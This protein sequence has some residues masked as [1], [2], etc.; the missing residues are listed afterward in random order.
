MWRAFDY[1][2][3]SG[4]RFR[5]EREGVGTISLLPAPK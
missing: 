4:Y 3:I 1:L 2:R 5:L